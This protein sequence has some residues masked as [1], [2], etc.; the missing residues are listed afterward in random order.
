[1]SLRRQIVFC[2]WQ[3][4]GLYIDSDENNEQKARK[5]AL[6]FGLEQIQEGSRGNA[7]KKKRLFLRL[8]LSQATQRFTV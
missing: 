3:L 7:V 8:C 4:L 5:C 1:M 2:F 6:F